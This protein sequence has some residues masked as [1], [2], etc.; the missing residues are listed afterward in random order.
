MKTNVLLLLASAALIF[1]SCK[2][3]SRDLSAAEDG[4][5]AQVMF[6]DLDAVVTDAAKDESGMFKTGGANE[7]MGHCVTVTAD[8]TNG[9]QYEFP[10]TITLD[11]GTTNC[12]GHDGRDRRGKVI[13]TFTGPYRDSGTVV[14][15]TTD[16]YFVQDHQ[17]EGQKLITNT[18]RNADNHWVFT[19]VVT[20][21]KITDPNGDVITWES[22]R[23]NE[24]IEGDTTLAILDDVYLI[25]GTG[26]GVSR[27]GNNFTVQITQ[28]LE[29]HFDCRW[30]EAGEI[31]LTPDGLD[32]RVL[33]YGSGGCD[34]MATLTIGSKTHTIHLP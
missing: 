31:T 34:N 12:T 13:A 2:R 30:V 8:W 20:N 15:I 6:D 28:T 26:S 22:N 1:S 11:F 29:I 4:G 18:G 32:P 33:N 10:V 24:W 27:N 16:Q 9:N 3:E 14:T 23:T 25:D 19:V 7:I 5:T 21:G 17:V